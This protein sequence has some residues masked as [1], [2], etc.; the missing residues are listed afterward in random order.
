M[1][2]RSAAPLSWVSRDA[3]LMIAARGVRTFGQGYLVVFIGFYLKELGFSIVQIGLFLGVGVAGVATFAFIVGLISERLGRR[4][5]LVTFALV[6]CGAAVALILLENIWALLVVSFMGALATGGG[7][8]GESAAQPLEMASLPDT[9]PV[10]KR[11]D[12]FAVYSIVARSG[13]A[14]GALAAALPA[15]FQDQLGLSTISS[16]KVMF[17]AF[18]AIQLLVALLY[19]LLS[20]AIEGAPS[21]RQ[22]SNPFKLPSRRRI[23]TLTGL[24]SVDTFTTSMVQQSLIALWFHDRFGL[25]PWEL[26]PIFF[27]S[28]VLTAVSLWVAAKLANRIGL[29]NTMVFTH[30]PS[31]LFFMVAV[32]APTAWMAILFWQ[33]RAFMSQMDVPTKDSY[34]MAVVRPEERVAMASL[35]MVGRSGTGAVGPLTTG[36][37]WLI[38][39]ASVPLVMASVLKITY[40][41]SL[42]LMF[43]NVVPPEEEARLRRRRDAQA[44]RVREKTS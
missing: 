17:G 40:D 38:L 12:L 43:R 24:F 10:E 4:R 3:A 34:T 5:L 8:G 16:Y 2:S 20:P 21:Q 9:A 26:G 33:L 19:G 15:L 28:H 25:E 29:L 30:I 27:L 23:F 35:H 22:W 39:P 42:Y 37:L 14:L 41:L 1:T 13:S 31:S 7:G 32:F 11:T 6:S 36:G 18:A 44:A